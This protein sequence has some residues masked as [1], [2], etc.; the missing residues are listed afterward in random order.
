VRN[1]ILFALVLLVGCAPAAV[2][3]TDPDNSVAV[4]LAEPV[5]LP[6]QQVIVPT[7]ERT[8]LFTWETCSEVSNPEDLAAYLA[9]RK[10]EPY[11]VTELEN[12]YVELEWSDAAAQLDYT[13]SISLSNGTKE[14][15]LRSLYTPLPNEPSSV[16]ATSTITSDICITLHPVGMPSIVIITD[17]RYAQSWQARI[18]TP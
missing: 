4:M 18:I 8:V 9:A 2:A 11:T 13:L 17:N 15:I 6:T 1:A 7:A 5:T 14:V 3:Q 12:T 10:L 16:K